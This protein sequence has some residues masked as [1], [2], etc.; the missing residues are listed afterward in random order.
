MGTYFEQQTKELLETATG[1]IHTTLGTP[2]EDGTSQTAIPEDFKTAF[3]SLIDKVNLSLMEDKDNFYGY[4]LFQ[5]TREIRFDLS[6]PTA[7][8]FKG[9]KY[10]IYY[11]P[12]IFL[13]LD[14]KMMESTIKHEILHI[15]SMHLPRSKELGGRYSKAALNMAMDLAVNRYL[16][17]LPPYAVTLE[18]VN[19]SYDL[20]LE[21]YKSFEY[22]AGQLQTALDLQEEEVIEE[23]KDH[24]DQPETEFNTER[25][26]DLWE[27]SNEVE[28]KTLQEFTEKVIQAS[29]KG[30]VPAYLVSLLS[31]LRN[32]RGELPWNLYLQRL[33]GTIEGNK[34]KTVTRRNRRQPE[35]LDLRGQLRSH[36]AKIALAID[37]SG[38]ISDEEFKQAM[39]EVLSIVKNY[40]HEITVLECD[41]TIRREY[42]V[43]A[44]KD[45]QERT[46]TRGGTRF[47]P[48]FEYANAHEINLL[49]YF[50]DGKGEEKLKVTPRGYQL[51]WVISGRGDK[52]SLKE[53]YGAVKKL[54]SINIKEEF[55][56]ISDVTTSGF[57]MNNQEKII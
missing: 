55:L 27:E 5:M 37:I 11:N 1:I 33:M 45:I 26:H 16:N 17:P 40:S 9:A 53:P 13:K 7:V 4:F 47:S 31:N 38:S 41:D 50:T 35:R 29:E 32:S 3:F 36:K 20:S 34:K 21:P 15:V 52:L 57:S 23:A 42:K 54:S 24:N 18:R 49:I 43:K 12:L 30:E 51:L 14:L 48:V 10:V 22:Y 39:I 56:D 19:Q 44:E 25:T 28:A 8:N 46:N 6:S 2:Q